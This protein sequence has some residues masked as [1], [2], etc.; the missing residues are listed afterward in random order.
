MEKTNQ[1]KI[2]KK[3]QEA[4]GNL[5]VPFNPDHWTQMEQKLKQLDATE[6]AF[7]ESTHQKLS[8]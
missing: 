4:M 5:N 8:S 1:D 2:D 3:V 6:K 7:D